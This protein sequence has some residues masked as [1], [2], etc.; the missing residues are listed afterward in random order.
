[1]VKG[2]VLKSFLRYVAIID[3]QDVPQK[4]WIFEKYI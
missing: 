1:M 2:Q 4:F 3:D